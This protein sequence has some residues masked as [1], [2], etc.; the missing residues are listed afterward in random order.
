MDG[1]IDYILKFDTKFN[2]FPS[3]SSED[4][5]FTY[6]PLNLQINSNATVHEIPN[7]SINSTNCSIKNGN[8]LFHNEMLKNAYLTMLFIFFFIFKINI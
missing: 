3:L 1:D 4:Y 6:D 7:Q 5:T 2:E 8:E